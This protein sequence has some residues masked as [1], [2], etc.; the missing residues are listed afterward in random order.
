MGPGKLIAPGPV[1]CVKC[2]QAAKLINELSP[3]LPLAG[4]DRESLLS[5]IESTEWVFL[6]AH[7]I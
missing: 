3:S 6:Y 4:T 7:T 5:P 2:Q 1:V